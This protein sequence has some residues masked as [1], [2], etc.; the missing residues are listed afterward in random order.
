M[1]TNRSRTL[2]VTIDRPWQEVYDFAA[3]PGNMTQWAA[4]LGSSFSEE[5]ENVW[6]AR[7]EGN[8]IRIRFTPRNALGVIDHDVHVG[9]AVVHVASRV[10]PN[11]D[12]AEVTFLLLQERGMTDEEFER[13]AGLV[14]KDLETLKGMLEGE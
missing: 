10:M 6:V 9:G 7:Q 8:P 12:G 3:D 1:T 13:D 4:G 11:G 2:S 14:Q 5:A